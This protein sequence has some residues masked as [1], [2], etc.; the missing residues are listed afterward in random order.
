VLLA[1][2]G[3]A[4]Q[5]FGRTRV[6]LRLLAGS[7][8]A[9]ASRAEARR[10]AAR[11]ALFEHAEIDFEGV[12]DIGHGFADELFRVFGGEHPALELQ[13][14]GMNPGVHAVVAGVRQVAPPRP[15]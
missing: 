12:T 1:H 14:T 5:A 15:A 9:L 4:G 10:V 7:E 11:L 13:A 6:P 2:R 3:T 8:G